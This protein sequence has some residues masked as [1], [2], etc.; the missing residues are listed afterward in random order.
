MATSRRRCFVRSRN[1]DAPKLIG[2]RDTAKYARIG[3]SHLTSILPCT[4]PPK[5][6]SSKD[7]AR[8]LTVGSGGTSRWMVS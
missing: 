2:G 6:M 3:E 1:L 4:L 8:Q 5:R 7:L